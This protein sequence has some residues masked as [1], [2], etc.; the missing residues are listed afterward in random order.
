M[1]L[2]EIKEF[3]ELLEKLFPV[4]EGQFSN[5]HHSFVIINDKLVLTINTGKELKPIFLFDKDLECDI[6][7]VLR[8]LLAI[9]KV[10]EL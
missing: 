2:K 7:D 3:L 4:G 5:G 10:K 9:T 6:Y 1:K 8:E